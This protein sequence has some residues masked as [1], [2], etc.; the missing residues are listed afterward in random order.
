MPKEKPVLTLHLPCVKF[1]SPCPYADRTGRERDWT[2]CG[3][4]PAVKMVSLRECPQ[5][6]VAR[7]AWAKGNKK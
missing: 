7:S 5:I 4:R 3:V 6:D 2:C 1:S